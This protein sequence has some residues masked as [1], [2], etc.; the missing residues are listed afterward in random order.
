ML[1][2]PHAFTLR[3]LQYIVAVADE[4]S[5]RR[6]AA[7]CHVSQPSLSSQLAQVEEALG[8]QLFE[9][10]HKRVI[11]TAVGREVI[12]RTRRLLVDAD[13]LQRG[14]QRAA[15]PLSGTVRLGIVAT[16]APYLLPVITVPLRKELGR[17]R[18]EWVEDKTEA[19]VQKLADGRIEGAVVA[20]EA[21]LGDVQKEVLAT[22]PFFLVM[23]PEH[24]L[25][26]SKGG[27]TASELRG[28]ELLLL[29]DGHCF[30]DQ[31]L[32]V[33]SR[34]GA[35]EREFR[36]TSLSTLVQVIVG[37]GGATFL[38][39]MALDIEATRARLH[40]RPLAIP[41]AHRTI[42]LIWRKGS[43]SETLRA[44]SSSI[45]SSSLRRGAPAARRGGRQGGSAK[46][47]T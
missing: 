3:Q 4:L 47:L 8:V 17:L 29:E 7:R 38:P 1:S 30:R 32:E 41:F 24:P 28:Q 39:K 18:I 2:A 33:C 34:A 21:D 10:T 11:V 19:L 23:R 37:G 40:V 6:A 42:G 12:A 20:L 43:P 22:D 26:A 44:I 5:F 14:A 15:D 25:A 35:N 36:A 16:I 27:V 45:R 13:E 9:R 46:P 31:A